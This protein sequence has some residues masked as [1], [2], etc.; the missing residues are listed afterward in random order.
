LLI[1]VLNHGL[2]VLE[3]GIIK[4]W[5]RAI[6]NPVLNNHVFSAIQIANGFYAFGTISN[7]FYITDKAGSILQ[8]INRIRGLQNNTVLSLFADK[9]GNVWCGLDNG[10][11]Y[12]ETSSPA[13]LIN[14]CYGIE[15]GYVSFIHNNILYLGTNQGLFAKAVNELSNNNINDIGLKLIE[16]TQGQVWTLFS[17]DNT[18]LC[19]HNNGTFVIDNFKA[20]KISAI[21]GVWKFFVPKNN[22]SEIWA[23][24]YTG[25]IV[26]HKDISDNWAYS[27]S[28]KGFTES[29]K[30]IIE[31]SDGSL[32]ISHGYKGIY[33]LKLNETRDSVITAL[34][35][36]QS[37][38]LPAQLPYEIHSLFGQTIVTTVNGCYQYN[39]QSGRFAP[40]DRFNTFFN[41]NRAVSKIFV[42]SS[43][44]V[45]YTGAGKM[46][47]YRMLEDGNYREVITPFYK[48]S[49]NILPA[50]EHIYPYNERNV[51]IGVQDGFI[52]YDPSVVKRYNDPYPVYIREVRF[53]KKY[54]DSIISYQ[55]N[56]HTPNADK[57]EDFI[58]KYNSNS[59]GFRYAAPFFEDPDKTE[60]RC[61]LKGYLNEWGPWETRAMREYTN[62]HEG[63]YTFEVQ[64]RNKYK[65][66]SSTDTFTFKI[67]PPFQRSP[68]AYVIYALLFI[69]VVI[70]NIIY[71]RRRIERTRQKEQ[72]I[73][74][75]KMLEQEQQFREESLITEREIEHLKNE[76][77]LSEMK[78]KNKELANSTM[79]VIQK[80]KFLNALK[81]ELNAII[82]AP[83]GEGSGS[84]IKQLMRKIDKDI[85]NEKYFRVFD[86]YFDDVHQDFL[87]RLKEKHPELSPKELRLCAYIR[88]NT[89]SKEIASLLNIS[90]R[91][92]EVSRYRL[93]KKM[94][95]EHET[96]LTE[97]ILNL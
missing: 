50:F 66:L 54:T 86:S 83:S 14:H 34:L 75:R 49:N 32:L 82:N 10:I 5:E 22:S 36:S 72:V 15:T 23:G 28:L 62:L 77:L 7:G 1:G 97:Y 2:F 64:A 47:V 29:C 81:D 45:W 52:H 43:S 41:G 96:N 55:G 84:R 80:N 76:K 39:T 53:L 25:I 30:N 79:H 40:S 95:I 19:G 17:K 21:R 94:N 63:V 87:K 31:D 65:T 13:T 44:N 60:Y 88:M 71:F 3:N 93:R 91:G 35:Y 9:L 73:H 48:F 37:S 56:L 8:H 85:N 67:L 12:T 58:L 59:V 92:V 90:I 38:G 26:F 11:S 89:S 4:P 51:F 18:L 68:L 74:Q 69:S 70:A 27:Y 16:G 33:R 61:R 78:H 42:D 20:T 46:G 6:N 24:T 57:H